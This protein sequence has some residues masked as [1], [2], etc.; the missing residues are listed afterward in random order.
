MFL[1]EIKK[2]LN[3]DD[4]FK[5]NI[6]PR[7]HF[8]GTIL[9]W[10]NN[11]IGSRFARG[12]LDYVVLYSNRKYK[13]YAQEGDIT[14]KE[15]DT[16]FK[17]NLTPRQG[18]VGIKIVG[19]RKKKKYHKIPRHIRKHYKHSMCVVCGT[20]SDIV[21][22][23]KDGFYDQKELDINDFQVLCNHCNLVKRQRYKEIGDSKEFEPISANAI[24][25][26]Q[27]FSEM[28]PEC[29]PNESFW[30]DPCAYTQRIHNRLKYL[31][32]KK[33]IFEDFFR[34][35]CDKC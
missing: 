5:T 26:L 11:G 20:S 21:I 1:S 12:K 18:I 4:M 31:E 28:F 34:N 22:D 27:I 7:R 25:H 19:L 13:V 23:H 8:R 30:Y 24:P 17:C 29:S 16:F 33:K 6:I 10:G 35:F 32:Q 9:D 14:E 3:C 15:I 2:I